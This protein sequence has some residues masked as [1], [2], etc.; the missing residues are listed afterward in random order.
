MSENVH[1]RNIRIPISRVITPLSCQ[2]HFNV[3][4]IPIYTARRRETHLAAVHTGVTQASPRVIQT[5]CCVE[6]DEKPTDVVI[7]VIHRT[8]RFS[9]VS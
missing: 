8:T 9:L 1:F 4:I 7:G 2:V 5:Y 6:R 3:F